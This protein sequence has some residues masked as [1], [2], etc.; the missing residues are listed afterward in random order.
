VVHVEK[1]MKYTGRATFI[2]PVHKCTGKGCPICTTDW[3]FGQIV[4]AIGR[5]D[6]MKALK[7]LH[8]LADR[9]VGDQAKKSLT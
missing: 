7:R 9:L 2:N 6:Q 4:A 5:G 1:K 8:A 3:A